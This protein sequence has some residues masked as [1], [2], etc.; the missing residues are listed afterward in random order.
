M[1][2]LHTLMH[3]SRSFDLSY[4]EQL[5]DGQIIKLLKMTP[6]LQNLNLNYTSVT[7]TILVHLPQRLS[8]L[9]CQ[10]CI[11][12]K[13]GTFERQLDYLDIKGVKVDSSI[14]KSLEKRTKFLIV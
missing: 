6:K 7:D 11:G 1:E 10:Y 2:Q 12:L 14:L 3:G 5:D 8:W 9:S 4:C 13:F